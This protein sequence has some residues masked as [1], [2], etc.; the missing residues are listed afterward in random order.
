L[1]QKL[2]RIAHYSNGY[3]HKKLEGG[4]NFT[5]SLNSPTLQRFGCKAF[6]GFVSWHNLF[7]QDKICHL[8]ISNGIS[9]EN[10][11]PI[12]VGFAGHWSIGQRN[13]LPFYENLFF[14]E[15]TFTTEH[16]GDF[17]VMQLRQQAQE[18][19]RQADLVAVLSNRSITWQ[20]SAGDWVISP[21]EIRMV[22]PFYAGETRLDLVKRMS[23]HEH[24]LQV[25][26][27]QE[28][29]YRIS[30]S[31]EDFS[32]FYNQLYLPLVKT[33]YKNYGD[34]VNEAGIYEVFKNQGNLLIVENP[35]GEIISGGLQALNNGVIYGLLNGVREGSRSLVRK[36]A[37]AALY[38]FCILW[39][40]ENGYRKFD[41]GV[42]SSFSNDGIYD[43]K[44]HWGF[45]PEHNYWRPLDLILWASSSAQ[46]AVSWMKANP[47]LPQFSRSGGPNMAAVQSYAA[48]SSME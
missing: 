24:N 25:I 6:S 11:K 40:S 20:P 9:K 17:P 12:K 13:T 21:F 39:G 33:R 16:C 43:H 47:F 23:G 35:Q 8:Y 45:E 36:G 22:F 48:E 15:G 19:S 31:D 10:G 42:C 44:R 37:L 41:A 27:K 14:E 30:H 28:Y 7:S 18:I 32:Y 26:R 4:L 5:Y 38:Y 29:T 3:L 34:I 46:S 1:I 2:G